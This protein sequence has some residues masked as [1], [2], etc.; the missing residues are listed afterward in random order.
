MLV[1]GV[2]VTWKHAWKMTNSART[3]QVDGFSGGEGDDVRARHLVLALLVAVHG[4][5]GAQNGLEPIRLERLVGGV[6]PL[7]VAGRV[8]DHD[9]RVAALHH[10]DDRRSVVDQWMAHTTVELG[11]SIGCTRYCAACERRGWSLG[12]P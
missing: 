11:R 12:V 2:Y 4:G 5:L 3:Y 6:P 1:E 10:S 9:R 7:V 8:H